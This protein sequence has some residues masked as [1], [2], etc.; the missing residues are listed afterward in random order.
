MGL[1]KDLYSVQDGEY[2]VEY[3]KP[4][5]LREHATHRLTVAHYEVSGQV[6][7]ASIVCET[8][9]DL[10]LLDVIDRELEPPTRRDAEE[11]AP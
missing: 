1:N 9:D 4:S 3:P 5:I 11:W 6:W 10:L 7:G 8:C 2:S